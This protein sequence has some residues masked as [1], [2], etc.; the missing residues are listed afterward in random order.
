MVNC[1]VTKIEDL[2]YGPAHLIH[3]QRLQG[4]PLNALYV[5]LIVNLLVY[6]GPIGLEVDL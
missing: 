2:L 4:L 5:K 6:E 3:I 1:V